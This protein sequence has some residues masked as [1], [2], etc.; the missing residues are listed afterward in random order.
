MP[1]EFHVQEQ[2]EDEQGGKNKTRDIMV[3]NPVMPGY[4]HPR[5]PAATFTAAGGE[6]NVQDQPGDEGG[7]ERDQAA[8]INECIERDAFHE[9]P[10]RQT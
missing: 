6:K 9:N 8:D 3:Q 5:N 1:E 10:L 7:D 2:M 4:S